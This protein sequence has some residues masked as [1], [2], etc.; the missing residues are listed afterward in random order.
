MDTE[1]PGADLTALGREQA[2]ALPASFGR[3]R[4]EAL[5]A[6]N[7]VRTQQTAGPLS[8]ALGLDVRVREG[9]R[10]VR[11][12]TLEMLGDE[13]S[14]MLYLDTIFAWSGGDLARRIP[15]AE[16]G[17]EVY[18]RYDQVIADIVD[19][20]A[21]TAVAVSHGAVIRTWAAARVQNVSPGFAATHPLA[22]TG[23]VVLLGSVR[24]GWRAQTWLGRSVPSV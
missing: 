24:E 20:G 23:A 8:T 5:Y 12:G 16:S 17:I 4:I 1:A 11:A 22:N 19:S 2:A 9:L 18:E 7:L 3:Y 10:E 15:G 13:P 21:D 14:R 6:S